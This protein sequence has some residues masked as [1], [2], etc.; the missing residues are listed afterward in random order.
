MKPVGPF[1]H[2]KVIIIGHMRYNRGRKLS[3]TVFSDAEIK[4]RVSALR[5]KWSHLLK[6]H[7]IRQRAGKRAIDNSL[8][9]FEGL[10]G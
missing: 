3:A 10:A 5:E 7:F 8:L 4:D 6:M 9:D 1:P 2:V